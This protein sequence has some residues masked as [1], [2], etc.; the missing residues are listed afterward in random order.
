MSKTINE[1]G[2]GV[3]ATLLA[4]VVAGLIGFS[5]WYVWYSKQKTDGTRSESSKSSNSQN[6]TSNNKS[7]AKLTYLDIKEWG[8]KL[9]LSGTISD[10]YY[11]VSTNSET[12][13]H[14]NTVWLGLKSLDSKG[15]TASQ[16][17]TGGAYPM[18]AII[19]AQPNETDPVSGEP[20]KRLDPNGAT[21]DNYYYA[22]HSGIQ[23]NSPTRCM[24]K[25]NITNANAIDA[26]F[27][28]AANNIVTE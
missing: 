20:I 10:A 21:I 4:L 26:A 23:G 11:V 12:D 19:K 2:F 9:P 25:A 5:G 13:G 6:A 8:I 1:S 24:A 18:G 22:Y 3:I 15:C 28:A 14:P 17:N 16:A 27:E 7:H